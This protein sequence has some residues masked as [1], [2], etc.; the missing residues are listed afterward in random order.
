MQELQTLIDKAR[1][2]YKS[3]ADLARAMGVHKV[4][5][6]QF[7]SGVRTIT[8]E[9]VA[10]LCDVLELPGVEAQRLAAIAV[11]EAAKNSSK[12]ERLKRAFFGCWVAGVVAL[13]QLMTPG[14]AKAA[15]IKDSQGLLTCTTQYTLSCILAALRKWLDRVM[16]T[17]NR[18]RA[19]GPPVHGRARWCAGLLLSKGA[20]ARDECVFH[21]DGGHFGYDLS[22]TQDT[23]ATCP[24]SPGTLSAMGME[25]LSAISG[26][27]RMSVTGGHIGPPK[28]QGPPQGAPPLLTGWPMC[29]AGRAGPFE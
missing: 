9:T 21:A 16:T 10:I 17:A 27:R 18:V 12:R 26:M 19:F 4:A 3:D 15:P 25:S 28:S 1:T 5:L 24:P 13:A 11:V 6:A 22:V 20:R 14:E 8:P 2:L 7:R 23:R 29:S